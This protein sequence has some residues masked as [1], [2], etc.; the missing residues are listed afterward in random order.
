[1][2]YEKR[3]TIPKN[4]PAYAPALTTIPIH[5]GVLQQVQVYFPP[6]CCALAHVVI[7]YWERQL[8]P[9][10]PDSD[11]T[12]DDTLIEFSE[13]LEIVDPPYEF[14]V[15]GW[16]EDDTYSHTIIV[17]MQ[18]IPHDRSLRNILTRLAIG[19]TGPIMYAGE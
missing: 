8:F 1:M 18:I 3:I 19:T 7:K 10:N 5:P 14:V 2:I 12:G 17:R 6:G 16:N 4:T 15:L 11:F 9:T 13:D